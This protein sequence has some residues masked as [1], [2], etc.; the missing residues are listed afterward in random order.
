MLFKIIYF[1]YIIVCILFSNFQL[2]GGISVRHVITLLMLLLCIRE[3]GV[4]F[5]KFVCCFLT[6]VL[7]YGFSCLI[8]GYE[9]DFIR[10]LV[11]TYLAAIV[12][13]WSSR[14]LILKYHAEYLFFCS[15]LFVAVVNSL[16]TIGQFYGNQYAIGITSFFQFNL[17]EEL[18]DIYE[19]RTDFH[20]RYVSGLLNIVI[21]GYFLSAS[22]ILAL[23]NKK[24]VPS[25]FNWM[26]FIIIFYALFLCQERAGLYS[27]IIC[28]FSLFVISSKNKS[29]FFISIGLIAIAL[30]YVFISY[31]DQLFSLGDMRYSAVKDEG[32]RGG[33]I[34]D[35]IQFFFD[36][37]LGAYEQ[38]INEGHYQ[39]HNVLVN[40][41]LMGGLFGGMIAIY[42][43]VTQLLKVSSVMLGTM[44]NNSYS[45]LLLIIALAYLDYTMNSFFHNPSILDGTAMFFVLWGIF[46]ALFYSE[47]S[48]KKSRIS[49]KL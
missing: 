34:R 33:L 32:M 2:G 43:I 42:I 36:H 35:G 5:D 27:A 29:S 44:R 13:Y 16:I 15:V 9:E 28:L 39:A 38:W 19:T 20:G 46:S 22:S 10:K 41:L 17:G 31:G 30:I 26:V 23:Y 18:V 12:L 47:K 25:I 6:F 14:V 7:F 45:Y 11:G 48:S 49:S 21:N 40:A 3:N 4:R 37:P 1:I 8:T 24:G